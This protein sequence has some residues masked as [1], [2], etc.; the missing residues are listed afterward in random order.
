M[1]KYEWAEVMK[2]GEDHGCSGMC[3]P[4]LFHFNTTGRPT[5]TCLKNFMTP[6]IMGAK[7]IGVASTFAGL[8]A[9]ALFIFH[10]FLYHREYTAAKYWQPGMVPEKQDYTSDN[11]HA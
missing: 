10:F 6:V 8:N 3:R 4:S 7:G 2:F 9:L 5:K 1:G 11:Q